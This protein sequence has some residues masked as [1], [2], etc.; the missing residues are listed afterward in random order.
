LIIIYLCGFMWIYVDLCGFM[1]IYVDL[2]GFMW[3]CMDLCGFVWIRVDSCGFVFILFF[4][5]KLM[6]VDITDEFLMKILNNLDNLIIIKLIFF[7]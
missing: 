3:I 7:Y 1:W 4:F 5:I 2:C 6:N